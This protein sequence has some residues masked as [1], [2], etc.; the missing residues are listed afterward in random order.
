MRKVIPYLLILLMT[1][2]VSP[3]FSQVSKFQALYLLNFSKNLDWN[4]QNIVIGVVGNTKALLELESIVS[5]YPN[6][7]LKKISGGESVSDC[8]LIFLPSSQSRNFKLIQ[9]KIGK[10]STVL[11]TEDD[12]LAYQGAE[13]AFFLE[14]N[15]LKF[16]INEKALAQ[17][18][19]KATDKLLSIAKLI[20]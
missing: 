6:V 15:K 8:Q 19:V 4:R 9:D 12:Q 13:I 20:N 10:A 2:L 17:S 16:Y 11:V 18:G 3:G 7:S 1:M 5:K 14:G